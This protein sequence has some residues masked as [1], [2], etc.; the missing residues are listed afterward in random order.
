MNACFLMDNPPI[1]TEGAS[2]K[3]CTRLFFSFIWRGL[4]RVAAYDGSWVVVSPEH[5][6]CSGSSLNKVVGTSK[7][8]TAAHGALRSQG[9]IRD[10]Q[11][12]F[13]QHKPTQAC[14]TLAI[15]LIDRSSQFLLTGC[16]CSEGS[17]ETAL[18]F[19]DNIRV[20][21]AALQPFR[22]ATSA[23]ASAVPRADIPK[24]MSIYD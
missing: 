5:F 12:H 9:L 16:T 7:L 24:I 10:S 22:M 4:I 15:G 2:R 1:S 17:S 8:H 14:K 19:G 3:N 11:R 23:A 21:L 6:D 13:T 20:L 18:F